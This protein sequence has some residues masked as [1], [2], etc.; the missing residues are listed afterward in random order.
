MRRF[1]CV[2]A[3][4]VTGALASAQRAARTLD[5]YVVDVEG[6]KATLFV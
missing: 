1:I 6:G 2:V 5:I 4:V 3:I